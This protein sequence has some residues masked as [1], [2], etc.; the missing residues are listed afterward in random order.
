MR[1]SLSRAQESVQ[2]RDAI[3]CS[4]AMSMGGA[5]GAI[6][7]PAIV[8]P[9]RRSRRFRQYWKNHLRPYALSFAGLVRRT[10]PPSIRERW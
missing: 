10:P 6:R 3:T 4:F 7:R 9:A 1:Q 8:I 5:N 2:R